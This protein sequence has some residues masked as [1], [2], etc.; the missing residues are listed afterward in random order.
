M[1]THEIRDLRKVNGIVF[2]IYGMSARVI[3]YG[4]PYGK[5]IDEEILGEKV[6]LWNYIRPEDNGE[7]PSMKL[8]VQRAAE[9]ICPGNESV[10]FEIM[11]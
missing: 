10:Y 6:S 8:L 3:R 1:Q 2:E 11:A 5:Y 4:A 9:Q 7:S